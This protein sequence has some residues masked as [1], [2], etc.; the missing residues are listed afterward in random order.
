MGFKFFKKKEENIISPFPV[1]RETN[2]LEIPPAPP[3]EE[4]LPEFPEIPEMETEEKHK[5]HEIP[6]APPKPPKKSLAKGIE[7]KAVKEEKE[8]LKKIESHEFIKPLFV[9]I[10]SFK[11]IIDEL[12]HVKNIAKESEEAISRVDDFAGDQETEF[13]R[14]QNQLSDMQKKLIFVDKTIFKE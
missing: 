12:G 1:A 6:S 8:E 11:I 7:K 10:G 14:W 9:D 2:E 5:I 4:D 13:D 3:S